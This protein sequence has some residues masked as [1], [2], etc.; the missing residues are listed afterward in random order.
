MRI[1]TGEGGYFEIRVD[2]DEAL[3][4]EVKIVAHTDAEIVFIPSAKVLRLLMDEID[5]AIRVL[6][7]RDAD[8]GR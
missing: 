5:R 8:N 4:P 6:D 2:Y 3:R 7:I 1:E